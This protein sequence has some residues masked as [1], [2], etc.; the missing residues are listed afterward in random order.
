MLFC[1]DSFKWLRYP[2]ISKDT[3]H[4]F[5]PATH[6]HVAFLRKNR[7]LTFNSCALMGLGRAPPTWKR[8]SLPLLFGRRLR[9]PQAR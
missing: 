2:I 3:A 7:F 8:T 1:V 4:K 9:L 5:D 6:N